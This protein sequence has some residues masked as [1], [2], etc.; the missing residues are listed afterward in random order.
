MNWG[1]E[2]GGEREEALEMESV[3]SWREFSL[4]GDVSRF[5]DLQT[6]TGGVCSLIPWVWPGIPINQMPCRC[7][8]VTL[9]VHLEPLCER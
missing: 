8:P 1:S 3:F 2:R 6:V 7:D 4:V 9:S 5:T